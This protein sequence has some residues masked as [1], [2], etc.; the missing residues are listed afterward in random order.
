MED[1]DTGETWSCADDPRYTSIKEGLAILSEADVIIGH[2]IINFDIPALHKVYPDWTYKGDPFDTIIATRTIWPDLWKKD[3]KLVEAGRLDSQLRTRHSLL[4]WGQRLGIMKDDFKTT[5]NWQTW[6]KEMQDYGEQDVTVTTALF[7]LIESKGDQW[8]EPL[9]LEHDFCRIIEAQEKQGCVFDLH[10][11][12]E[13][14]GKLNALKLD[15]EETL[16]ETFGTWE[17][18]SFTVSKRTHR[19]KIPGTWVTKERYS[20][21]TGKRLKDYEGPETE[22]I[23]AGD[24]MWKS[25]T[26]TFNPSSRDHIAKVLKE[27]Y[28]WKPEVF[29]KGGKPQVD[30][31]MLGGLAHIPEA[32]L[33]IDYLTLQKR[34]SMLADGKQAWIKLAK[35][36]NDGQ[37]RIHGRISHMGAATSRVTHSKPN[38]SQVPAVRSPYGKECR[39]LFTTTPGYKLVGTDAS[40]IQLRCLAHYLGRFDEGVYAGIVTSGDPHTATL[41]AVER[42]TRD[43]GKTFFYAYIF[44]AYDKKL[45]SIYLPG[46]TAKEQK[47]LGAKLR[48]KVENNIDGLGALAH[49]IHSKIAKLDSNGRLTILKKDAAIR[50]LDGR[51]VP[52]RSVS[53][54]LN[55]ALQ[56]AEAIIMKRA[57]LIKQDICVG[58]DW[59]QVMFNHDEWQDE[60]EPDFADLHGQ[61]CVEAIRLAGEFYNLRCPLTGEYSIGDNWAETH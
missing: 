34:I 61:N 22:L 17:V 40:G 25:K 48:A 10:A 3:T 60:C 35:R 1:P 37:Q 55:S 27:R 4:S 9:Q 38:V 11:A 26:I 36:S 8:K 47:A 52:I 50:G 54:S 29:T 58:Y 15:L 45:G 39:A 12:T 49:S 28:G 21:K 6:T 18:K 44:G 42:G 23:Q 7:K 31:D 30:E 32:K 57:T 14:H 20:E 13:L 46:D 53:A 56:S 41:E 33:I 16:V 51:M 59:R 24:K 43:N 5:D 2:N 19:R